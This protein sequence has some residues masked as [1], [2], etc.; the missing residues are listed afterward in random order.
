LRTSKPHVAC[1]GATYSMAIIHIAFTQFPNVIFVQTLYQKFARNARNCCFS[2]RI[3][4]Y[5]HYTNIISAITR[6]KVIWQKAT[7]LSSCRWIMSCYVMAAILDLIE[8]ETA[9]FDPPTQKNLP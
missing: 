3:W 9:P 8:A 4:W 1:G 5:R 6:A 2:V 7:L